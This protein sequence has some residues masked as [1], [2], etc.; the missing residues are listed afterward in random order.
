MRCQKLMDRKEDMFSEKSF[1]VNSPKITSVASV[2]ARSLVVHPQPM[3]LE[4]E[5]DVDPAL[6]K[7]PEPPDIGKVMERKLGQHETKSPP[8]RYKVSG[9][10]ER[11]SVEVRYLSTLST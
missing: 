4:L 11:G 7:K 3:T 5:G 10:R 8:R 6:M 9:G 2:P 1:M